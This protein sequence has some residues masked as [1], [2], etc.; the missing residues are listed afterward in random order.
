[1]LYL[2]EDFLM[3]AYNYLNF[4][5]DEVIKS[6][7]KKEEETI[8]WICVVFMIC[9]VL[10]YAWWVLR[11]LEALNKEVFV[12]ESVLAMIPVS[13]LQSYDHIRKFV[14]SKLSRFL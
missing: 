8:T 4:N 7:L 9:I 12:T 11:V 10:L 13:V 1:M 6:T 3:P 2:I 5:L 14:Q